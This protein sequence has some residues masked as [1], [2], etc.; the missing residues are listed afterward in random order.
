V[1]PDHTRKSVAMPRSRQ[2]Y[3][4]VPAGPTPQDICRDGALDLNAA[5]EFTGHSKRALERLVAGRKIAFTRNGSKILIPRAALVEL[6]AA[7]LTMPLN[8]G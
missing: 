3:P 4:P 6:L 7:N 2:N 8:P 1:N 5:A